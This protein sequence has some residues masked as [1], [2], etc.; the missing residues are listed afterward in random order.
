MFETL[1][2]LVRKNIVYCNREHAILLLCFSNYQT[3]AACSPEYAIRGM[4]KIILTS[5]SGATTDFDK[6]NIEARRLDEDNEGSSSLLSSFLKKHISAIPNVTMQRKIMNNIVVPLV[7]PP[8]SIHGAKTHNSIYRSD[9]RSQTASH[10]SAI[11][12][13]DI[14]I[15]V[16][17]GIERANSKMEL[18]EKVNKRRIHTVSFL[19]TTREIIFPMTCRNLPL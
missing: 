8:C 3:N 2:C 15:V 13:F 9:Q 16:F 14:I 11:A 4:A 17:N 12:C 10:D 6:D 7:L 19:R 5:V 18:L 1:E